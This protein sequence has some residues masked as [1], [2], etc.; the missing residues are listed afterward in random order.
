MKHLYMLDTDICSYVIKG[1]Y[2]A[3][4]AKIKANKNRICMSSI[5]LAELLFGAKK[6]INPVDDFNR[7]F[8]QLVEVIPW[9]EEAAKRYAEIRD[10]L[11]CSGTPIG[12]MDM[13]IAAV[14][15]AHG[16]CLVTNNSAHFSRVPGLKSENW[17]E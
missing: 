15:A 9:G 8:Q 16:L 17:M 11:E 14:A 6:K 12:N 5:T 3:L 4:N 10:A 13:L 7:I 1:T 2:P